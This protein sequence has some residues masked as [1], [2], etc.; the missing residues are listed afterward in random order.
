M[1][2]FRNKNTTIPNLTN[3][4]LSFSQIDTYI[5]DIMNLVQLTE[6]DIEHLHL[7]DKIMEEHAATIAERHYE[8]IMSVTDMKEIFNTFTTYDRY[9]P[10]IINYYKQLTKPNINRSYLESRVNIGRIHSRIQLTEEW[11]IGSYT[12]VTEYLTPIIVAEFANKPNT[13]ANILTALQKIINFDTIVVLE[14]YKE[15]NEF[16]LINHMNDAM[17]EITEIDEVDEL[18]HVVEQTSEE[19]NEVQAATN[20]LNQSFEQIAKSSNEAATETRRMAT[21]A[22]ESKDTV[23]QSLT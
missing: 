17:D 8:I 19:A 2:T 21:E 23:E 11:F 3:D 18:L 22:N 15:A 14:A 20:L 9:V 16:I 12:R 1:F 10:A 5:K 4:T 7:I 13:L 6:N